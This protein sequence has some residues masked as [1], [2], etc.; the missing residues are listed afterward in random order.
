MT[1]DRPVSILID[2]IY[3][4]SHLYCMTSLFYRQYELPEMFVFIFVSLLACMCLD[5]SLCFTNER[6]EPNKKK[7]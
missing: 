1:N 3:T 6:H 5:D 4:I 7:F 2:Q